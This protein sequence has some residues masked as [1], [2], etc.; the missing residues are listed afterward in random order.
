MKNLAIEISSILWSSVSEFA[1]ALKRAKI[2]K[3]VRLDAKVI[4]VGNLQVGGAGKTPL[5]AQI[6]KEAIERG[7]NICILTRGYQGEWEKKGG[8]LGPGINKVPARICGDEPALLHQKVP[9]AYLGIGADRVKQYLQVKSKIE[10]KIDVILLDDGFQN[11][12]IHKDVEVLAL[13][14]AQPWQI[15]FRDFKHQARSAHLLVWTKGDQKPNTFGQPLVRLGF[16]LPQASS[17]DPLWLVTGISDSR[18]A[19]ELALKSGYQI[20][21]HISLKDHFKYDLKWIQNVLRQADFQGC[22]IGLTGK[23]WVKWQD[24]GIPEHKVEILEPEL[25]FLEGKEHWVKV[26]WQSSF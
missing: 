16:C 7:L 4:S 17:F 10:K 23:D 18:S 1:R 25:V 12:K 2:L 9:Q 14:S 19:Y 11:W 6:A 15:V 26:L 8:V 13:T 3:S 20:K 21:R 5:V 24:L 22:R